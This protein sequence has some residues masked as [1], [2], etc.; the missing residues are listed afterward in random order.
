MS[1]RGILFDAG[2]TLYGPIGGRWNS[3]FDFEEVLLRYHP[4]APVNCFAEAIA[5]G[6]RFMDAAPSTP[7]RDDYHRAI[8]S[9]LGIHDPSR[10]L[11]TDLL[12]PV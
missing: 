1:V 7:P 5:A 10:D 9:E 11:L 3:R 8:L 4:E 6:K 2:D 12:W